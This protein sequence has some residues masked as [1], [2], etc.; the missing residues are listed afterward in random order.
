MKIGVDFDNTICLDEWPEI[1]RILP[2]ALET[3]KELQEKGHDLILYTQRTDDYITYCPELIEYQRK[4]G[5]NT[6]KHTVDLLT[7]V[8]DFLK[9]EGLE[10]YAINQNPEWEMEKQDYGRKVYLDLLIDDHNAGMTYRK[11]I[12]SHGEICKTV[13]W[14]WMRRWLIKEGVL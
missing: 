10:F 14:N 13:D 11:M 3:L 12:N 5:G 9:R 2:G 8:I 7:P 4:H 6:V 1:G